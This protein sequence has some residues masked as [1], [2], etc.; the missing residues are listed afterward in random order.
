MRESGRPTLYLD[1]DG[2]LHPDAVYRF[3]RR[4]ELRRPGHALFECAP[5]LEQHLAP[6]P[7]L[8]IVLST[9]WVRVLSYDDARGWLP[10][11]LRVRVV[12]ATWHSHMQQDRWHVMTRFEQVW[13]DV[14]RNRHTRW[15]AVDNDDEGW[16]ARYRDRLVHTADEVGLADAGA[17]HELRVK[18]WDMAAGRIGAQNTD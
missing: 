12:G 10:P 7:Q 5:I 1:F 11:S 3:G 17:Q 9:S 15:L 2:V 14:C 4:I 18:L 6:Y 16:P 8:Q 13:S